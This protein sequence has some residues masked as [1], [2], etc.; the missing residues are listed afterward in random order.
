[1]ATWPNAV[2]QFEKFLVGHGLRRTRRKETGVFE[3]KSVEYSDGRLG[4]RVV[5]EKS[6]WFVEIS[7]VAGHPEEW[8]DA[9]IIR[10]LLGGR[11]EDALPLASQIAVMESNWEAIRSLFDL[12]R[13][14][15]THSRLDGL[16]KQRVRRMFP[17]LT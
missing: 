6:V 2:A 8:Y 12:A 16:R 1:M 7:D 10:D 14:G 15:G 9:A 13:R 11:G 4:V 5:C 3:N 17:G